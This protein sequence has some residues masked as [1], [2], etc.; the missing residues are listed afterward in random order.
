MARGH[1]S[2]LTPG[3]PA[4]EAERTVEAVWR[5]ESARIVGA[6]TRYT[7]DF[8][9]AEESLDH[10]KRVALRRAVGALLERG[11]LPD[12]APLPA[13]PLRID[14]VAIDT[15]ADGRPSLRHHRGFRP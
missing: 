8:G 11:V 5:I 3:S 10:R 9:L 6:L 4:D 15:A 7:G 13:L 14:L 12:G 1:R 2:A